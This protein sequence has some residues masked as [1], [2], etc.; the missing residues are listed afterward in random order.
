VLP[1]LLRDQPLIIPVL[2]TI[3]LRRRE[4]ARGD[5]AVRLFEGLVLCAVRTGLVVP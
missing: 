3:V 1:D 2:H 4:R 5:V